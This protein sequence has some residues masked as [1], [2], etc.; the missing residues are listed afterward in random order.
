MSDA[1]VMRKC[2]FG[3]ESQW[4][5]S[6]TDTIKLLGITDISF[7]PEHETRRLPDLRGSMAPSY[8]AVLVKRAGAGKFSGTLYHEMLNYMLENMFGAA[9]PS[10]TGP[11]VRAY[12]GPL[13]T[14]PT[15]KPWT[16]YYGT[17]SGTIEKALGV[18]ITKL[19][20]KQEA[21]SECT[22]DAEFVAQ[23]YATAS[24]ASL[25]DTTPTVITGDQWAV[26]LDVVGGTLGSTAV[27]TSSLGFEYTIMAPIALIPHL[28][29][30]VA[31]TYAQDRWDASL[32]LDL[33]LNSTAKAQVDALYPQTAAIEKQIRLTATASASVS[34]P[35][36]SMLASTAPR[37]SSSS[38]R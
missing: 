30:L 32:K 5:T 22:F 19:T 3:W 20:I 18:L 6:V 17:S 21:W 4:G 7:T 9:S 23:D 14:V 10:G 13:G 8:K 11:Y 25:S 26:T 16:L 2:Q 24:F 1:S 37:R 29:S 15:R 38:R 28:G 35:C 33:E 34:L 12:T 31:A 36:S 27:T